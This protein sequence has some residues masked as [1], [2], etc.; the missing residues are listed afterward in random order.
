[1]NQAKSGTEVIVLPAL[2]RSK[3][4]KQSST[5]RREEKIPA[6]LY[7]HGIKNSNLTIE[8]RTFEKVYRQAGGS[9][10]IDLQIGEEKPVKVLIQTV[11]KDP[12][13]DRFIHADLHQV[14]MTEKISAT[15]AVNFI[16]EA[17]AVKEEGGILVKNLTELKVECLPQDLVQEID[18]PITGLNTFDDLIRVRDLSIPTGITIKEKDDEVVVSVQPPRSEEELKSLEEKPEEAVDKVEVAGKEKKE[19]E[20]EV[21]EGAAEEKPAAEKK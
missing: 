10:L 6:V 3:V 8:Y 12:V 4:G 21:A 1:M 20:E 11:Q 14:R 16:G 7:G 5:V 13:S 19:E 9:R 17:K 2:P 15:I 18:V